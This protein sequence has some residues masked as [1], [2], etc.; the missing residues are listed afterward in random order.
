M[1]SV[2]GSAGGPVGG[3]VELRV[4]RGGPTPAELAVAVALLTRRRLPAAAR[5][6]AAASRWREPGYHAPGC[7][8][9]PPARRPAPALPAR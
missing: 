1:G 2:M 6:W 7:W 8:C 4:V 5:S 9:L 3:P